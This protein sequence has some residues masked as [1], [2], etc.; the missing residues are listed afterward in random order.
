MAQLNADGQVKEQYADG[1]NLSTRAGLHA[2]YSTNPMGLTN[3]LFNQYR[4]EPGGRILELGCGTGSQWEGR[5]E[6]L[7]EGCSLILS[8]F[9]PGMVETVRAV[10]GGMPG[11]K[12][13]LIDIQQ[14]PYPDGS[15][16]TAIANFMLYHVPDLPRAIGEVRRVLKPGGRFYAATNGNG[17]LMGFMRRHTCIGCSPVNVP[18]RPG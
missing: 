5:L 2:K 9:S 17:G 16:D 8:D 14:I 18:A 6:E 7:P 3:W 10:Y 13:E 1:K 12:A 15:F 11:V 4:F